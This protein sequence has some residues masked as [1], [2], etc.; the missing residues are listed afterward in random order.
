MDAALG[1][2]KQLRVDGRARTTGDSTNGIV[3][4][5]LGNEL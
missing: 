2:Q 1:L 4:M 3:P 5:I